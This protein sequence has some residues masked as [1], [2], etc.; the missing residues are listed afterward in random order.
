MEKISLLILFGGKSTEHEVS[1]VSATS[2]IKNADPERYDLV[3]VGITKDGDWYLYT[4]D[5][6]LIRDGGWLSDEAHLEKCAILPSM[7]EHSLLVYGDDGAFRK[8]RIDVVFPVMHGAYAEDGTLQ[9]LLQMSGIPFVGCNCAVSAIG[10]DKSFTKLILKNFNIRQA[11]SI[12]VRS[13]SIAVAFPQ[14]VEHAEELSPY[15]LFVKPANAGSSVGASKVH[16][17]SELLTAL[18]KAAKYDSKILIEE[19]IRGKEVEV[20]V[21]GNKTYTASTPG[22]IIPGSEFYDYD[23]KYS[24]DSTA[25]YRVP[26]GIRIETIDEIRSTAIRI[27]SI[28]GVTGLSRVD[29]FVRRVS[30]REEIIFNEINT[31][32]G[33]T[34]ISMYPKLFM[35]DGM[36]Y[37]EIVDRLVDL[38]LGKEN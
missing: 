22:E 12:V 34:E 30:G 32:P 27:A 2:I 31:L 35:H 6:E 5:P 25:S 14:L 13:E 26:A 19:Y 4:G 37:P 10:M 18:N 17:R 28:L 9:G 15:P 16:E 36:T 21:M 8:I 7:S 1:L 23:T 20:A 29:F 11:R 24:S 38:A 3:T 33:F